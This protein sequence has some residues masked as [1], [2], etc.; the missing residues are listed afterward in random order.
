MT[1]EQVKM[2]D[3]RMLVKVLEEN[4]YS[5]G[6]IY[7]GWKWDEGTL[8]GEVLS[9]GPGLTTDAGTFIPMTVQV[10]DVVVFE[11]LT[12]VN[13]RMA[14]EIRHRMMRETEILGILEP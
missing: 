12:G 11:P 8:R 13:V 4:D 10:G 3:D 9:V 14:P 2:L 6:G 7:T 5:Q 1:P